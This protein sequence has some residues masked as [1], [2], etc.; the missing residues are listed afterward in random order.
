MFLFSDLLRPTNREEKK[1]YKKHAIY[2]L[3]QRKKSITIDVLQSEWL[4]WWMYN[5][6]YVGLEIISFYKIFKLGF[7][8]WKAKNKKLLKIMKNTFL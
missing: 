3:F 1:N 4:D 7:K 5:T 6:H 2:I 8:R